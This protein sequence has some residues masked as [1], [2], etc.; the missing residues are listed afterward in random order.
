MSMS[1]D[2]QMP[3]KWLEEQIKMGNIT[4]EGAL[5]ILL[6]YVT[7]DDI[8]DAFMAEMRRAGYYDRVTSLDDFTVEGI[9]VDALDAQ[10]KE[11]LDATIDMLKELGITGLSFVPGDSEEDN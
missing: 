11:M 10:E 3:R 1:D 2:Y 6:A 7:E 8:A 9:D 4:V 5:A